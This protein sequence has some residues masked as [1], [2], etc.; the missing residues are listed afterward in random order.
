MPAYRC[1][2]EPPALPARRRT[3]TWIDQQSGATFRSGFETS[4]GS[5]PGGEGGRKAAFRSGMKT[6]VGSA[7]RRR[8]TSR[9]HRGVRRRGVR[10]LKPLVLYHGQCLDGFAAAWVAFQ[11]FGGGGEYRAVQFGEPLKVAVDGRDV[12]IL[13]FSFPREQ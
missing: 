1:G 8:H 2:N 5:A 7:R 9:E 3:T 11:R 10:S 6:P 12:L 13:D 4:V